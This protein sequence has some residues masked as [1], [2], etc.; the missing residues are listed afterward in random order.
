MLYGL[1]IVYINRRKRYIVRRTHMKAGLDT[2]PIAF[3]KNT[4]LLCPAIRTCK[5][6]C[7]YDI[8]INYF[9]K[10]YGRDLEER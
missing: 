6:F 9:S 1:Y 4:C 3:F 8:G 10:L 2:V 5:I 7:P